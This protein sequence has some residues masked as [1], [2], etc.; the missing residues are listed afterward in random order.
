M[1]YMKR[2]LEEEIE[3]LAKQYGV[4]LNTAW[5]IWCEESDGDLALYE[6]LLIKYADEN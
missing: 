3:R 4:D 2:K 5:D 1:S 6:L